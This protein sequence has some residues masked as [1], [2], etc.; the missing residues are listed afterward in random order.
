MFI[1]FRMLHLQPLDTFSIGVKLC[2]V[3][4]FGT[5]LVLLKVIDSKEITEIKSIAQRVFTRSS[6]SKSSMEF[7]QSHEQ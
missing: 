2:I 6:G 1:L 7:P 4:A 3:I 5:A